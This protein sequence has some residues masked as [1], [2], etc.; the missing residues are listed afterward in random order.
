MKK[1]TVLPAPINRRQFLKTTT[2]ASLFIG[3]S[4]MFP[5]FL[6]CKDSKE[7][8]EQL[9]KHVL[10]HWVQLTEDGYITI[11]NPAAEMGQ[12]SMTSLPAIFAEEMD[13][14]WPNV[15][16][17][18]SPQE[19]AIYGSEGWGNN[20]KIMLSAGSRVTKGYY[21]IMRM[22]GAQARYILMLN[23]ADQWQVPLEM[24]ITEEGYVIHKEDNRK[25]SYGALVPSLKI[26][27]TIPD[28]TEVQFKDPS[29]Y[30]LIGKD[31][32]RKEIPQKVDGSAQFTMDISMEDMVYAVLERGKQH[33]AK[34]LL[35]NETAISGLHGVLKVVTL[36]YAVGILASSLEQ[37]LEA[38]K[39]LHINWG[40]SPAKGFNSQDAF[41]SYENILDDKRIGKTLTNI[42][43]TDAAFK[44]AAK[45][46]EADFKN[47]YVYH[48]QM[49]PLN[50]IVKISAD[51]KSAEVW[52]GSQQGFD[53]KLGVPQ[54]LNI[55]PENVN[56]NLQ[57]LGGGF[58]RRSM[59]D[60]VTECALMAKEIPGKPVKLMW[61]REDDLRYGAYRPLTLQRL[62]AATDSRGNITGFSHTVVGDGG[63]LV[64]SGIKNAYYNI[65]NQY[66]EWREV[67]NGIR[68][69]H[70]RAVGHGPNKFA[71]ESML[72]EVAHDQKIDPI[73]LRRKLM[74]NAPNALATLEKAASMADWF[75][76]KKNGRGKGVAFLERSGTLSTGI[77]EISVD[78]NTG[79][80]KV[81][82]FWSAHDAGI[83][84]QPDNVKAQI[85]GG[86]LMGIG[87]VLTE[88]ITVIDGEVQ[89]SN[90]NDYQILRMEDIP[91]SVETTLISSKG[92]PQGVGESGTPLV[93]C[94]IANAFFDLTGK[95]L[96]H[97]PFLPQRVM[98]V[99]NS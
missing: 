49:E 14:Y 21:P 46:Y 1:T 43:A 27:E 79:K 92:S 77:C 95:K 52:V 98:E 12:G 29:K 80:I 24:L 28:F 68:L 47:D 88:Q 54:I 33:G 83:I 81:H 55:P 60:F 10:T 75:G 39:Q 15:R 99:L 53:S 85:E 91:D 26:P 50:S 51:L 34:P 67:S 89:Q 23:A 82:H 93:A 61:T 87:S 96:R 4:G 13:V 31:L 3:I 74:V 38:K 71:I 2:G 48:A 84:I 5:T 25:I 16:V 45:V 73:E 78:H 90:F 72:D 86:I 36:D 58:G 70:W 65:P 35:Q 19:S 41:K 44:K 42:G 22:A 64:A 30:R 6:A 9:E 7:V 63:N 94:A 62:K 40:S 66:A 20:G 57:Y 76:P 69:K 8:E 56:I 17:E 59:T 18:F 97:L 37:A 11:F 32:P